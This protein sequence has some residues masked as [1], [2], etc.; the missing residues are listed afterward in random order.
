MQ[1]LLEKVDL[2]MLLKTW[3]ATWKKRKKQTESKLMIKLITVIILE[4]LQVKSYRVGLYCELFHVLLMHMR[5]VDTACQRWICDSLTGIW[6]MCWWRG[7][8]AGGLLL[9]L[10]LLGRLRHLGWN[11]ARG[12]QRRRALLA[13]EQAR[14]REPEELRSLKP[15]PIITRQIRGLWRNLHWNW[16]ACW[17]HT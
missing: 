10:M 13:D 15:R 12:Q 14:R 16:H 1:F 9:L 5:A 8:V 3:F 7:A 6:I 4:R 11:S 2:F 17:Y